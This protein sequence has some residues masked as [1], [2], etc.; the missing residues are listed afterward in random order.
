[1][2]GGGNITTMGSDHFWWE[3][4]SW[5]A[6]LAE[7]PSLRAV[8]ALE[9]QPCF[10]SCLGQ[11]CSSLGAC[12]KNTQGVFGLEQC[13]EAQAIS[14]Q[15]LTPHRPTHNWTETIL[16]RKSNSFS[17]AA[18]RVRQ[19]YAWFIQN[20]FQEG[21]SSGKNIFF[22]NQAANRTVEAHLLDLWRASQD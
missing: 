21:S 18:E 1:M 14:T 2:G 4:R 10:S 8:L 5:G 12:S 19:L 3:R 16:I 6:P 7:W 22:K 13:Q 11:H 20:N 15:V 17:K 9:L